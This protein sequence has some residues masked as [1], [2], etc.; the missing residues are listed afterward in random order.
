MAHP[1]LIPVVI[2]GRVGA[3]SGVHVALC[4]ST[5]A[6][7]HPVPWQL[8]SFL[9]CLQ[10]FGMIMSSPQRWQGLVAGGRGVSS[11]FLSILL[12]R[13][14][15]LGAMVICRFRAGGRCCSWCVEM[16]T[17]LKSRT[18]AQRLKLWSRWCT[19]CRKKCGRLMSEQMSSMR[20]D[21]S[22]NKTLLPSV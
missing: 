15:F 13:V 1:P 5:W 16:F 14:F 22:S 20:F 3:E 6:V 11:R 18:Q 17:V 7:I 4:S 12:L 8:T 2:L 19:V 21:L 9:P 10:V